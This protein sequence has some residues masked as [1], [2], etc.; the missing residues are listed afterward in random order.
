MVAP[1]CTADRSRVVLAGTVRSLTVIDEQEL[2]MVLIV[3]ASYVLIVQAGS[4]AEGNLWK[5]K[6]TVGDYEFFGSWVTYEA[7]ALL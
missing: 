5:R 3:A 7:P 4:A 6:L 2:T 1:L